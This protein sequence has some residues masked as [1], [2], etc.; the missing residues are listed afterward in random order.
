MPRIREYVSQ[1]NNQGDI[2]GRRATVSDFS[3]TPDNAGQGLL[4]GSALVMKAVEQQEV[5]DIDAKMAKARAEWT[6]KLQERAASSP[7]GD[8]SFASKFNEDFASY[9]SEMGGGVQTGAGRKAFKAN[10]A[11]LGAHFSERAGLYQ[12]QSAG[13]KAKQDY[14]V[15]LDANRNTVLN[16]P[17]QFDSILK[18]MDSALDNPSG[19]YAQMPA[20]ARDELRTTTRKELALSTAQGVIRLDPELGLKKLKDGDWDA[21]LDADKKFAL[22]KNAEVG[23]QGKRIEAERVERAREKAEQKAQEATGNAFVAKLITDPTSLSAKDIAQ[24]N[25]KWEDKWRF[26]TMLETA[27]KPDAIKTDPKVMLDLWTRVHLPD[28]AE[29]KITK[30]EDVESM[31]GKGLSLP[32]VNALR[33]EIQGRRTDDGRLESDLKENFLKQARAFISDSNQFFKDPKGDENVYKF[34]AGFFPKYL[35]GRRA[36]KTPQQMLDP[37]SPD[38]LGRDMAKYRRGMKDILIDLGQEAKSMGATPAVPGAPTGGAATGR[39]IKYGGE[40]YEVIGPAMGAD[41]KPLTDGTLRIRDPKTGRTATY[42]P[43]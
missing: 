21:Y 15:A 19:P 1:S 28:G 32:D 30:E 38:Y 12:I 40:D 8:M 41:G 43:N 5:S 16:D 6:V 22:E 9:L 24:S 7:P 18:S 20:A 37:D 2:P 10:A 39:T 17:T 29:G 11:N 36:G 4:E 27:I 14:S 34:M 35:D 13:L 31:F 33:S 23:I 26:N 42:R 3:T 25:L